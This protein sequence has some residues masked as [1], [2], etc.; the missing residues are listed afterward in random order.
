MECEGPQHQYVILDV[1]VMPRNQENCLIALARYLGTQYFSS[2]HIS[3]RYL[4]TNLKSY[5]DEIYIKS[6]S[7]TPK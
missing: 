3:P 4:T 6:S 1:D 2:Y 7:S 5:N